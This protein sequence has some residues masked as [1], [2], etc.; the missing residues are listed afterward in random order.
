MDTTTQGVARTFGPETL[1]P[2]LRAACLLWLVAIGA[3]VVESVIGASGVI[4]AE[5]FGPGLAAN[6]ALRTVVY[7]GAALL[8]L[9]LYR[10]RGWARIA[11]AVLLGCIGLATLVVPLVGWFADGGD[12]GAA[13]AAADAA[14]LAYYTV[15]GLHIAAV[16]AAMV[17]MF[18]PSSGAHLRR[19]P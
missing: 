2:A 11:L 8:V 3:G 14:D 13:L 12:A 4:A 19:R 15:R 6:I 5:G 17:A 16:P 9:H 10:G 1:P 18:L 7:G